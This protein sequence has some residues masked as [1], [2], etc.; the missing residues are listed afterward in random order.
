MTGDTKQRVLSRGCCVF[1][2]QKLHM[3][4]KEVLADGQRSRFLG[5]RRREMGPEWSCL[6]KEKHTRCCAF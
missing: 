6:L 3:L 2:G 5:P 4:I 1:C